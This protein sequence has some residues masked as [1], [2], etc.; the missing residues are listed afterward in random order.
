[1]ALTR[2]QIDSRR[3]MIPGRYLVAIHSRQP[4]DAFSVGRDVLT[5]QR[6]RSK[7]K[8]RSGD[9]ESHGDI[10]EYVFWTIEL[11]LAGVPNFK[12]DDL[13]QDG[14]SFYSVDEIKYELLGR[15]QRAICSL[16]VDP[17]DLAD[18]E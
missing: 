17:A 6:P 12:E 10:Y 5:E 7:R 14:P 15:R 8:N 16:S 4:R 9:G 18:I 11:E 3:H 2:N 1:M 13:I